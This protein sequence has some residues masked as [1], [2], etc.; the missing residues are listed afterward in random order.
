MNARHQSTVSPDVRFFTGTMLIGMVLVAALLFLYAWPTIADW[1][2]AR[3]VVQVPVVA[4]CRQPVDTEQLVIIHEL[5]EGRIVARCQYVGSRGTYHRS[6]F[7]MPEPR[8]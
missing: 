5:R 6:R 7:G 4:S 2:I 8:P 3:T 1:L